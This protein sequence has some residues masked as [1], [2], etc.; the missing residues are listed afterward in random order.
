VVGCCHEK[1]GYVHVW[2]IPQEC[3]GLDPQMSLYEPSIIL[4][5]ASLDICTCPV[6]YDVTLHKINKMQKSDNCIY[7]R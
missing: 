6:E 5:L 4:S 2:Q 1:L 3:R 7:N